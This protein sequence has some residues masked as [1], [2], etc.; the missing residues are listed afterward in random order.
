MREID[1]DAA[2]GVA[3]VDA[4]VQESATHTG[5]EPVAGVEIIGRDSPEHRF[6]SR[7]IRS[8]PHRIS[9]DPPARTIPTRAGTKAGMP[10]LS[11]TERML[12]RSSSSTA[13]TGCSLSTGTARQ[14]VS[15]S[16]KTMKAVALCGYSGT[17]S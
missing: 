10:G 7:S 4:A 8:A 12:R 5:I 11:C 15:T 6:S 9:A 14:Q 3:A 13:E 2:G 1:E 17:V 16:G